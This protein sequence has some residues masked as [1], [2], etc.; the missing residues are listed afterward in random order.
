MNW[1]TIKDL[2]E[3][4]PRMAAVVGL[5]SLLGA[6]AGA[7]ANGADFVDMLGAKTSQSDATRVAAQARD[8]ATLESV[9]TEAKVNAAAQAEA[10]A[11]T[12]AV[13]TNTVAAYTFYL[14]A[15]PGGFF[16]KQAKEARTKLVSAASETSRPPFDLGRLH[17]TVAAVASAAR[18]AA[19]EAAAK[20]TQAERA[21][22]MAVAA[23]TQARAN[24]RG[25]NVIRYRDRD[26][27]EGEVSNGKANG[28]G[29]Y[30]QGDARFAGDRFQGQLL[31]GMWNGVGI[32][33]STSGQAGRPVR[34]GGEFTGGQLVGMG[35]IIRADGS[36]QA[37]AVVSGALTGHGVETRADGRRFEGEFRNG[38]ANGF[39][40]LWS[41]QGR[42]VEAGR[43]ESGR[44]VQS[45][46]L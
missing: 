16:E 25:Y 1:E 45:L 8:A 12:T 31:G 38:Q 6:G 9:A 4:R 27:Y 46:S 33:E 37:G 39:G 26:T 7:L 14:D 32:F 44:L 29:V 20:Q 28:L 35:V 41:S 18:D 19:K 42:V 2:A 34:Y 23:A 43:Y 17:P 3:S 10:Q 5:V 22:N 24:A 36:R 21:A 11:W 30:V 15:F 40:V 13:Q